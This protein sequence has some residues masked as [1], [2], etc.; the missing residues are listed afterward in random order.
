MP[1]LPKEGAHGSGLP[2]EEEEEG[3]EIS[4]K[5]K[6]GTKLVGYIV[7]EEQIQIVNSIPGHDP[8]KTAFTAE[9]EVFHF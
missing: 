5:K 9:R 2:S 1:I 6:K 3:H 8:T 4:E 7:N